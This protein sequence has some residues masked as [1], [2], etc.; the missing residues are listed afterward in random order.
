MQRFWCK[1]GVGGWLWVV[2]C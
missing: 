1:W 2:G